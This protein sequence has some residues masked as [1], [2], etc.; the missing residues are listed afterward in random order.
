MAIPFLFS[1]NVLASDAGSRQDALNWVYAQEGKY[2][3]YDNAYGAQCVD[4]IKYYYAYFGKASYAHGNGCDYATNALPEGWTR[5]KNTAS[6]VP[7]PGDIAVWGTELSSAGHVAIILS[8]NSSSFVSMDQNWP[9][10]SACK[11]VTHKYNKFWGVIR[12]NFKT[13]EPITNAPSIWKN[14]DTYTVGDCVKFNWNNVEHA[15][16]YWFSIWYKGE[17]IVTTSVSADSEYTLYNLREGEYTA[18]IKAYNEKNSLES[19]ITITVKPPVGEDIISDGKYQICSALDNSSVV[20]VYGASTSDEANVILYANERHTNQI[21]DFKHLGDGYYQITA[22]HSGKHLD[23]YNNEN[24]SGANVQQYYW[25]NAENQKWVVRAA[26]DGY[27]YIIS[28]SN[29]L[30]LDVY[31]GNAQ[32]DANIDTYSGHGGSSEKWRLIPWLEGKET[33]ESGTYTIQSALNQTY[34]LNVA[35]KS[36]NAEANILLGAEKETFN[37]AFNKDGSY[38][39]TNIRSNK[40][41]D[42]YAND[43]M[44]GKLRGTNVQQYNVNGGDNQKWIIRSAGDGQ[45]YVICKANGLYLDV[46]GGKANNGTNIA[47]WI[48]NGNGCQKWIFVPVKKNVET[49][50]AILSE[51]TYSYDGSGKEPYVTVKDDDTV[52]TNGE[53]Y[54][55]SYNNNINA[56]TA[57]VM[58]TGTGRYTGTLKKQF[59]IEKASQSLEVVVDKVNL[60]IGESSK[61]KTSGKGKITYTSSNEAVVMV[62]DNG[63]VLAKKEGTAILTIY[64]SGTENYYE[65]KKQITINVQKNCVN[66]KHSWDEGQITVAPSCTERGVRTYTCVNCGDT[67][68]EYIEAIGHSW[69]EGIITKQSTC[70]TDGVKTY[71]CTRCKKTRT[72]N[73]TASGHK[74]NEYR[75][76]SEATCEEEGYTGD[77]YCKDCNTLL[78]KGTVIPQKAHTWNDGEY[79]EATCTADGKKTYTCTQC[80]KVQKEIF[81]ATGHQHTELRNAKAATCTEVGYTGDTY[82]KDCGQKLSEGETIPLRTHVWDSG[83]VEVKA[84]CTEKGSKIYTCELCKETKTEV[85]WATG[86]QHTELRGAKDATC[87][88]K[89]YTGDF[90]CK[91]CN[92]ELEKGEDIPKTGHVWDDGKVTKAATCTADGEKTY[93]CSICYT[94]Y[95]ESIKASGHTEGSWKTIKNATCTET[96]TQTISC[97]NCGTELRVQTIKALGHKFSEWKLVKQASVFEAAEYTR[98]CTRCGYVENTV[99]GN[100]ASPTIT[101]NA[102][103]LVL[104]TKQKT[105]KFKVSGLAAGDYVT[106]WKSTN[107]K[108]FTVTGRPDGSCTISAQKKTGTARLIVT[109]ASGGS[110]TISVKVQKKAVNVS[111]IT[112]I[113]RS[114]QLKVGGKYQLKPVVNP[115]TATAKATYKTSNKKIATVNKNG[116]IQGKKKGTAKI[117][118]KAGKKSVKVTVKVY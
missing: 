74:N 27:F 113:T 88:E 83:V 56:G 31:G 98:R 105:T 23:V 53:D 85:V 70:T 37:V 16:G 21:F 6:F 112:N 10:G 17:Q 14:S 63:E 101:T 102:N 5:I 75:N 19:G 111:S 90:Y 60:S 47:L 3:D 44:K 92:E 7:E 107:T 32:N 57:T 109:L 36:T 46:Y 1:K 80:G 41:L 87:T 106:G 20:S 84:T 35:G 15:T 104:K 65:D 33:I 68:I 76:A 95:T 24:K 89:G 54:I 100:A 48:G 115:I 12:P 110:K 58:I 66:E 79:E 40:C 69:D 30:Y 38:T 71:T 81:P 96:G 29:G 9:K 45:Y 55:V 61:I 18:F 62:S 4:L 52:L 73:I 11:Q 49:C 72:E 77:L 114:V 82:C 91:D 42:A 118:V 39:I 50:N 86:H 78:R 28:K 34:G 103:A 99:R 26:S 94:S 67:K 108:I 8:A 13:V 43:S 116:W 51:E 117:T 93:T 2:L 97:I 25:K 64:A 59:N 22:V